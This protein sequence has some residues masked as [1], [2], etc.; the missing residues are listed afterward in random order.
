[1]GTTV[2]PLRDGIARLSVS[3]VP[4][5]F[6]S[7]FYLRSLIEVNV[8]GL[9]TS[10]PQQMQIHRAAMCSGSVRI[11]RVSRER[12]EQLCGR[13]LSDE[14]KSNCAF[15]A[16]EACMLVHSINYTVTFG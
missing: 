11:R 14:E 15:Q 1:M 8:R 3:Y 16:P 12:R 4:H 2:T 10:P 13:D 6:G 5:D 7:D 9:I